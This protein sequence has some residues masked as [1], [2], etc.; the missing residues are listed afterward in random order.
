MQTE[1]FNAR[2]QVNGMPTYTLAAVQMAVPVQS[3][4]A[5]PPPVLVNVPPPAPSA[6]PPVTQAPNPSVVQINR[7]AVAAPAAKA[8]AAPVPKASPGPVPAVRT[9]GSAPAV[10]P[11]ANPSLPRLRPNR[12]VV[13]SP[14]GKALGAK[15]QFVVREY[16]FCVCFPSSKVVRR[17]YCRYFIGYLI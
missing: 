13:S 9:E 8:P 15:S 6:A 3:A 10:V 7:A 17:L 16:H 4:V 2:F 5:K 12:G 11:Q 14:T 1:T